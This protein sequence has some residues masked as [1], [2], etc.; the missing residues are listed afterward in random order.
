MIQGIRLV[1]ERSNPEGGQEGANELRLYIL[2]VV[3]TPD[4]VFTDNLMAVIQ[5][6]Y[7]DSLIDLSSLYQNLHKC[8][9]DLP[10]VHAL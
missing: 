1:L 6:G 3:P 10:S 9:K 2:W 4:E 8:L 5:S 7:P